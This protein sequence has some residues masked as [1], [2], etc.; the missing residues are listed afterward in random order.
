MQV[1]TQAQLPVQSHMLVL[2]PVPQA[3]PGALAAGTFA[4]Q[5]LPSGWA[6]C[7]WAGETRCAVAPAYSQPP[8]CAAAPADPKPPT[9][10]IGHLGPPPLGPLDPCKG[11]GALWVER[12]ERRPTLPN[13][14]PPKASSR[15]ASLKG[16]PE[17][18][19]MEGCGRVPASPNDVSSR[20]SSRTVSLQAD[21]CDSFGELETMVGQSGFE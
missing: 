21:S 19:V 7:A 5:M 3:M 17:A 10:W 13:A 2:C 16:A 20:A 1:Q 12:G 14:A 11:T 9:E 8:C 15:T 6:N 4:S 18:L